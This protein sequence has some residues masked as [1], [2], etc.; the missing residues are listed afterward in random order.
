MKSGIRILFAILVMIASTM[1]CLEASAQEPPMVAANGEEIIKRWPT[2]LV[3][4]L[5]LVGRASTL[6]EALEILDKRKESAGLLLKTLG[7]EM[8]TVEYGDPTTSNVA[9]Q[10]QAQMQAMIRQRIQRSGGK[11]PEGLKMPES[12]TVTLPLTV[13]WKLDASDP[14][15]LLRQVDSLRK[16][17]ENADIGGVKSDEPSLAEQELMEEA[18]S[19]GYDPYSDEPQAK[20]GTPVFSFAAKITAEERNQATKAAFQS[21]QSDAKD[22]ATAAGRELGEL[23]SLSSTSRGGLS[24]E[25][26]Y[27]YGYGRRMPMPPNNDPLS[28]E[29]PV[30]GKVSFRF[31][32]QAR[33]RLVSDKAND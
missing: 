6:D 29:T 1:H 26:M 23:M 33:F 25:E 17:I 31:N 11:M 28:T 2:Q 10:G 24:P 12:I 4:R 27:G 30:L 8:D 5:D 13:R 3:L 32:V 18:E 9:S 20:P 22:L 21:A 16:Q 14:T 15:K 7:A 19:F